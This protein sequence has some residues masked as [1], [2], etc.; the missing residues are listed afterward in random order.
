[1]TKIYLNVAFQEKDDAK[2]LGAQ[3]D[4]DTK[5]WYILDNDD[6]TLFHRWLPKEQQIAI[7]VKKDE[8]DPPKKTHYTI[9]QLKSEIQSTIRQK[10][11][12]AIWIV[13][14]IIKITP[15]HG[16]I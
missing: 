4:W 12:T 9:R 6:V 8:C 7:E 5:Q 2:S 1:M 10:F 16:H 13:G 14:E 15:K 3:F 11:P